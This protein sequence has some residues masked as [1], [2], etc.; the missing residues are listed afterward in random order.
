MLIA[1]AFA[2]GTY[3]L[4]TKVDDINVSWLSFKSQHAEKARLET[5]LRSSLGYGGMIHD[6]KN[7]ILRKDFSSLSRLQKSLGASTSIAMQYEALSTTQA[8]RFALEDIQ[9][10]LVFY[11]EGLKL[12]RNEIIKNKSSQEI[13]ALVK[14]DDSFALRG[15]DV[16]HKEIVSEYTYYKD[17]KQK[18]VLVNLIRTKLGFGGMIHSFKNYVLRGDENYLLTSKETISQAEVLINHYASLDSSLSEQTA[19]SDISTTLIH[20]KNKLNVIGKMIKNGDAPEAIDQAVRIN[21]KYALRGLRALDHDIILQIEN[22]SE[23]LSHKLREIK[24]DEMIINSVM[25]IIIISLALFL[26]VLLSKKVIQPVREL[27]TVMSKMAA[28]DIDINFSYSDTVQ[29]ELGDMAR[30]LKVFKENEKQKIIAE[31]EVRRLAMT[32]PLTGLANRNQLDSRFRDMAALARREQRFIAIFA[33]DLDKFKPINDEYGHAAGDTV[34][35]STAKN[36]LLIFRDTDL[37]VRIGGDEFLVLFYVPDHMRSVNDI[38]QRVLDLLSAPIPVEQ[39]LLSVGASIGIAFYSPENSE[40][41]TE[42]IKR[43][44]MALYEAKDAGRNTYRINA[45]VELSELTTDK[46]DDYKS[47]LVEVTPPNMLT[48]KAI[49]N[50]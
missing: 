29:T 20:Y 9:Q 28:G 10:M 40:S 50:D 21:D 6:F 17:E 7:Y 45:G 1:A 23:A 35:E 19:L 11:Q 33:L 42:L 13:D 44:D 37:V 24:K 48:D 31:K 46:G 27:S 49:N 25:V 34:L 26:F 14:I 18:S 4:N 2:G 16:L 39:D 3:Q 12:A 30:S 32:D 36:L 5:S 15:L 38:A 8:E 22:K 47:T 41:L 43:A